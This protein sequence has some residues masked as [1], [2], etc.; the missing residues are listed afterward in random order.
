MRRGNES[1]K[2]F[3]SG[4]CGS[5]RV[6]L[7]RRLNIGRRFLVGRGLM[8]DIFLGRMNR[9]RNLGDG[10]LFRGEGGREGQRRLDPWRLSHGRRLQHYISFDASLCT[11]RLRKFFFIFYG[12]RILQ[13]WAWILIQSFSSTALPDL[14]INVP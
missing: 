9:T 6:I 14:D 4:R 1:K 10:S 13:S 7:S 3:E 11:C 8:L 5:D 12:V 2:R